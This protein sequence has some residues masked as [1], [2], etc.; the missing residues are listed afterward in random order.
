MANGG[1]AVLGL[2]QRELYP[3]PPS[4]MTSRNMSGQK[5]KGKYTLAPIP[6]SRIPNV[7][8]QHNT[9]GSPAIQPYLNAPI[10]VSQRGTP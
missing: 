7:N 10:S 1:Q 3:K 4:S 6:S 2:N 9:L 8:Q 5:G